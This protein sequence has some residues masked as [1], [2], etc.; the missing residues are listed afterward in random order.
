MSTKETEMG[1]ID[2]DYKIIA[3]L[4]EYHKTST[5]KTSEKRGKLNESKTGDDCDTEKLKSATLDRQDSSTA[6]PKSKKRGHLKRMSSQ[7]A[8]SSQ[9][10]L[11]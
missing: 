11:A 4:A 3:K 2:D 1:D 8:T 5:S 6:K 9:V 7:Q 10:R